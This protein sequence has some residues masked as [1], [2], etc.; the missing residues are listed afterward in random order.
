[1]NTF[2]SS[3]QSVWRLLTEPLETLP[4]AEERRRAVIASAVSLCTF[5]AFAMDR[6]SSGQIPWFVLILAAGCYC[7]A[8]TRLFKIGALVLLF[9]LSVPSYLYALTTPDPALANVFAAFGWLVLPLILSSVLYST[10]MTIL[11]GAAN[12]CLLLSLPIFR[13]NLDLRTLWVVLC[14]YGLA[15]LF[16]IIVMVQRNELEKDRQSELIESRKQLAVEARQRELFAEQAQH[17]ADELM[18]LNEIGRV[19]SGLRSLNDSLHMIFEQVKQHIPLD[20]FYIALYDDATDIVSF[21]L[22]FDD[23]KEWQEYPSSLS[24]APLISSVIHNRKALLWNLTDAEMESAT[25]DQR[26]GDTSRTTVSMLISPLFIAARVV[27]VISA[28]SYERNLYDEEHSTLLTAIAQQVAIAV[29]NARLYEQTTKR[30]QRLAI[31]NEIGREISTLNELPTLME[32]VYRQIS[33]ALSTDLFFIGLYD[34][35]K[36][37][38]TFPIMYDNG[39]RWEQPPNKVTDGTFSGKTLLTRK[40]ILINRF[41]DTVKEGASKL[42]LVGDAARVTQSMMFVPMI[43]SSEATGVISVQSYAPNAYA[44]EDL[45][46]LLGIANQVAIALQNGRLLEETRQKAGYLS[47]LNELGHAVS[48]LHDLPTLLEIIYEQVNKHLNAD[49]FFVNIYHPET[50]MVSIPII[51]DSGVRYHPD[52]EPLNPQMFLYQFLNGTP[53]ILL[54]RTEEELQ[55]SIDQDRMFGDKTRRSASLMAAPIKVGEQVIGAISVQSYILNAYNEENLK[56]LAGIGNQIG[57]A[58]QNARLLDETKKSAGYL[59]I[60]NELGRVVSELRDL[61]DLLEV[62]NEQVKKHLSVDAFYV[63]LYNPEDNTVTYPITYDEGNRYLPAPDTLH[64]DSYLYRLMHGESAKLILRTKQEM[65]LKPSDVGMVGNVAK[66]SASLMIAPVKVGDQVIGVISVQSYTLNAYTQDD[67]YLL[68]GIGNQ[69]GVAIQNARLLQEI[70]QNEKHLA[71]LNEVGSDVSRIMDLPNLLEAVYGQVK[72]RISLNAFFVSLYHPEENEVSFPIMIDNDHRFEQ[73]PQK[74]TEKGFLKRFLN[75]EKSILINRTAEEVAR[76]PQ[77]QRTLGDKTRISA[78]IIAAPLFSRD[79]VIGL[80]SAQSYTL[81]AFDEKDI[82]LLQG[83]ASQVSIAIENSRLYSAAQQE[84]KERLR[85]EMDLQRERDFAVQ[86]M[87]TLGQGVAVSSLDSVYEYI[88]PAYAA[89]LGYKPEEMVGVLSD[90]FVHPDDLE[91]LDRETSRRHVGEATTYEL[92][93]LHKDRHIV[94]ALI[95]G[96]PRYANGKIIGAIAAVTDLTERKRTE[97][98]RENLLAQMEAKHAELERF[99]YTV[100]HDLKSPLVTI[101][102]FLGY[103]ETDLQNGSFE[104]AARSFNRIRDATKKMQRL[105][106]ELL[107]LSRIGRIVNPPENVP[108]GE[109]VR[110]TLEL[111]EGQLREKQV[112]VRVE[113]SFPVVHVDRVRMV[114]VIQNLVANSVKFMGK[115]SA[116]LIEIGCKDENG[117]TVFFVRDNG[118]G[119]APQYHER[120]FGLFNKLDALSDGTG[121]GLA[122]VKRIIE[123]HGGKIWVQSEPGK[124]ASFF[125]TLGA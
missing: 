58:V 105:L 122:L 52:Q 93:L 92:R 36:N 115:Q 10:R 43:F 125:F 29:E 14:F 81:N 20:V 31:I 109:L 119:I 123:V 61:P 47:I 83:I 114:E 87:N 42:V 82:R 67:L 80:I 12:L 49:A 108:F 106:D 19:I 11:F 86:V 91:R 30:A 56:L 74:I 75:G 116:P 60:L 32:N 5:I 48:E 34:K 101:A 27:G 1:M 25:Q 120:I 39:R 59:A 113:A 23:D 79:R 69:V 65:E 97:I 78:S 16:I 104:K 71:I 63:G 96:V 54:L 89:M 64:P 15:S 99:T 53:A 7:L 112:E 2:V 62:I 38:I 28:Q 110:E 37:E 51:Y 73:P 121:I 46:L 57:V 33:K 77:G 102:G 8:R 111:V 50:D 117:K 41:A 107:E 24:E 13:S 9:T 44:E 45:T 6:L 21:P 35:E 4:K 118:V 85:A 100:S 26:L 70:K 40:P 68:V 18:M 84:I 55:Q 124:G 66:K 72:K 98:E 22:V 17:R 103:L 95:T 88:N 76:G 94:H 90:N 3:F